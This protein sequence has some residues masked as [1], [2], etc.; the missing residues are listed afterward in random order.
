MRPLVV[1]APRS[2]FALLSSVISQLL[3]MD[4]VRYGIRQRLVSTAVRQAQYYISTAIEATFAAAGVG[5][6][7]IYNGNFKTVAGGPKW[8][9]ADDPS[10]ACFRKYLGVKGMG[11][12][13]LVIAHPAEV[14]ATDAIVHSHSHPRLWTELAQ[15]DDFLKFASVRNPIGIINS[16][17]FSLNALAS[18]YIQRYVDP[19]DD[20]DEMRQNL[21]L[22]KFSNLDF[23]AGIVRHYKGYFDE[24]LPVADRFHVTRWE[25]LIERSAETIRRVALQAGLVIEADHAGQIW[26][27]LDH[28]NLTGHHEH[29]YRRGK[30]LVGDWKNW[31][32]NA[33]LEIIREHGLEDA[34]QVFGY[35]RI[36]P[37]D[38]ARYTPFQRRVAELV[39]RGKVFEDHADLDLFGFAFN[40]SNI[41]ASAF[42]FRRYGWR[43]HSSVERSGFSDEGIVMAVWEAAETAAGELNA[44]LDQLLAGDYSSEARA[45]ASVEAAIAVSAAMAKRMPRATAA[46]ADELRVAARQAFADGSAEA[47][48]VDRSVPP[49]LIRSWN[50]Y[51]IVSHRG[52]FSAIPQA[53]GPI[54]LTDRDPHSIPGSIV[55]DSYESLRVAL[56]DGVAN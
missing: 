32:T 41:D 17:L 3:P 15:Y 13:I 34:M 10:R 25:D 54:D 56:S 6:R 51:N 37:L 36:E 35:G 2:G 21:A 42:A 31:M 33:H 38:E 28:I 5:D 44:V 19:R 53:V 55:R 23:F 18:E 30:G 27:R 9:K 4:P 20:N 45:T 40:K 52:Q 12:F 50:E 11:D 39:S 14:L 26:Q 48:E 24:F 47:L 1:G 46:M 16:S 8:L 22:F 43:L 49:L 7:L 29:N